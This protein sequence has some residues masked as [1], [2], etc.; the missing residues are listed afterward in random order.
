MQ[1]I[2]YD[3]SLVFSKGGIPISKIE[4]KYKV[5]GQWLVV[6]DSAH[7]VHI[8]SDNRAVG[9]I[10]SQMIDTSGQPGWDTSAVAVFLQSIGSMRVASDCAGG[11]IMTG[12]REFDFTVRAQ[13]ISRRGNLGEIITHSDNASMDLPSLIEL[14]Q[15]FPNPFNGI[16]TIQYSVHR[17]QWVSLKLYDA[18]G[19][20]VAVLF[21][22]LRSA[23]NYQV[24]L[25]GDGFASGSYFLVLKSEHSRPALTKLV[26]VK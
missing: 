24:P 9:G 6:S 23:G 21:Q 2:R 11:F 18:L 25:G 16:T 14:R 20:E 12:F 17:R 13:Q 5:G 3:G 22:G 7:V 15:N 10:Y 8:W 19:N 26:L 1:S 4:A